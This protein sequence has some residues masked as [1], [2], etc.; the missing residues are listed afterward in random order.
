MAGLLAT[1]AV[2]RKVI[3]KSNMPTVLGCG[4][5]IAHKPDSCLVD[6]VTLLQGKEEIKIES[7]E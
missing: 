2:Q 5:K 6:R 7:L 3:G 1:K 4:V